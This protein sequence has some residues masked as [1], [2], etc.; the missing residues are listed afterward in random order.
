MRPTP[1]SQYTNTK[2]N[3]GDVFCAPLA[4][5]WKAKSQF[6]LCVRWNS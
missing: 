6:Y 4:L 3:C 2:L 1:C 5:Q